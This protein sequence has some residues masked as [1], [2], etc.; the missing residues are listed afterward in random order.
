MRA[1]DNQNKSAN[2]GNCA[3][4]IASIRGR[5]RGAA[6][7][8]YRQGIML[9]AF[10][11]VLAAYGSALAKQMPKIID[12]DI[13]LMQLEEISDLLMSPGCSYLYTLSLCPSQ[14]AAQMRKL[15]KDKLRA[16]ETNQEII[17]YFEG[18]YGPRVLAQPKT[19]GFYSMAWWFP[20]FLV[21]DFFLVVG[22]VLM[23]WRRKT[24]ATDE[25]RSAPSAGDD[26]IDAL[27]EEEVRRF[28][29]D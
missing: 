24:G 21:F 1:Y 28:K 11:M 10:L 29:E 14:Q 6:H 5:E 8:I 12:D 13:P 7:L 3:P 2:H 4:G 17:D 9:L 19:S 20:Y 26:E 22:F 18:V 23:L 15:V 25:A 16:G 27:I